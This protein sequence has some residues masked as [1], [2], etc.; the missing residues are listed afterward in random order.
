MSRTAT[1]LCAVI[2]TLPRGPLTA[3]T[4]AAQEAPPGAAADTVERPL[5]RGGRGDRPYL[6]DL[7]GRLAIGGYAEGH[8]RFERE[9]GV[10]EALGFEAKRFN[11][12]FNSGISDFV[13]FGAELEFEDAAEEIKLEY[14][15]IDL[16]LH[17]ALALRAGMILLP[18]GRFNLSHDSPQNAFTDRP[19]VSTEILS[20]ALSQPGLG[21]FGAIPLAGSSRLTYEL[22][23]VNGFD[24][25]VLDDEAGVRLP[26]GRENFEND[27]RRLSLVG[28]V[29]LSPDPALDVGL[30]GMHGQY[31]ESTL[32]GETIDEGRDVSV[33]AIDWDG[34]WRGARVQGEAAVAH[35]EL[36]STLEGLFASRQWGAYTDLV[37]PFAEG[38][39]PTMP[40]SRFEARAR[41]DYVDF[42]RDLDGDDA[43]RVTVGVGFR[44]TADTAFKLDLF[45]GR[46]HDRFNNGASQGGI[47]VSVA[48][49]F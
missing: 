15:T 34:E 31:N 20:V 21:A 2:A 42:D 27:N 17:D 1:L 37:V 40:R 5:V 9:E 45:R 12:F 22:Y 6:A 39:I 36:P 47:L 19:F 3:R 10:T 4:A 32:D 26:R 35:I 38:W 25:G 48:T 14:M 28:R 46:T 43:L 16:H 44:P 41:I 23:A 30:S 29:A 13:R 18:L 7:S 33:A 11:L 8:L 49:Y 24:D